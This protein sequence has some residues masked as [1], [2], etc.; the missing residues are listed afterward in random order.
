MWEI[1][2]FLLGLRGAGEEVRPRRGEEA[3]A[4][5]REFISILFVRRLCGKREVGR[6]FPNFIFY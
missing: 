4:R 2:H 1:F 6:F 3:Q 5:I